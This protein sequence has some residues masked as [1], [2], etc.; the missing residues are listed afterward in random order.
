MTQP[1]SNTAAPSCPQP[2]DPP[3]TTWRNALVQVIAGGTGGAA[4]IFAC[5]PF[6]YFKLYAQQK[7]SQLHNPPAFQKNPLKWFVGVPTLASAMFPVVAFQFLANDALRKKLSQN[8]TH[9]LSPA[10]KLACSVGTGALSTA[11]VC[12]QELIWTQQ[13]TLQGE[14]D[15]QMGEKA[16]KMSAKE[17]IQKIW[18]EHGI[19]GFYRAGGETMGREMV[20]ASVL[21][22]LV[23]EYPLLA[24]LM[25]AALSQ[26]LDGR[27]TNKQVDFNY[28]APL[29]E[30][31]KVKA[32][33]GLMIG[34]IP[35]YLVFM[36]TAPLVNEAVK[37]ALS[38]E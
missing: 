7:A 35:I 1:L 27:K 38:K 5:G 18:R 6:F 25:G 21:T 15:N 34:R 2:N 14:L 28:K 32:F 16:P 4:G 33:S 24:P 29:R 12:P 20:C 11:F 17:V 8:G 26:P 23:A 31:C 30:M 3:K 36:N 9:E 22:N 19:K 13:Q 10:E 37:R